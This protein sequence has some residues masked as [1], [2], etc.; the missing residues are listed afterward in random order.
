VYKF[1]V[2]IK[3]G[4]ITMVSYKMSF[5]LQTVNMF[6]GVASFFFLS[7]LVGNSPLLKQ[8]R[9]DYLS[10]LILGVLFQNF[11]GA[12][13]TSFNGSIS[14][15][16]KTGTLEYLLMSKT[17]L[18]AVL[19]YSS[20]WA[21]VMTAIGAGVMLAIASLLFGLRL[22]ADA[23]MAL[24]ILVLTIAGMSGV[25]MVSAGVI[26]VT[27]QGDPVTWLLTALGGL[28]SGVY[29]PV[30]MLPPWLQTISSALPMTHALAAMRGALLLNAPPEQLMMEIL[31]LATFAAIALPLG[32]MT[33]KWGFDKARRDGTLA[34]Y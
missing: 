29:F 11:I 31:W 14:G 1:F 26:M 18:G 28:L 34:F 17:S 33:F 7:K 19:T 3:R 5:V 12:A 21:Y 24:F 15:E 8:Y 25:G 30:T 10:F 20:A 4:L 23:G 27:K 2:F 6:F 13:L 22:H 16:Q 9:G 32:L